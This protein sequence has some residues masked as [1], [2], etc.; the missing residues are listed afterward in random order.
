MFAVID[1]LIDAQ[2]MATKPETLMAAE[3]RLQKLS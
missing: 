1:L 2:L 3:E